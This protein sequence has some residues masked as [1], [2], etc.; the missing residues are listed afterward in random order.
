MACPRDRAEI[1]VVSGVDDLLR[2]LGAVQADLQPVG[3]RIALHRGI[4]LAAEERRDTVGIGLR[5]VQR[6]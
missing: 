1:R 6:K 4:A 5:G 3:I 2:Q